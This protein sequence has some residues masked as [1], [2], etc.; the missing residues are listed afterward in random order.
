[1]GGALAAGVLPINVFFT[2]LNQI[3]S[4][5][6]DVRLKMEDVTTPSW[7]RGGY[8]DKPRPLSAQPPRLQ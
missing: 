4:F 1:M 7:L 6:E 5:S 3:N 2:R 8:G